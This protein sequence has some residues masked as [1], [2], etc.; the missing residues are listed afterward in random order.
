MATSEF[1]VSGMTCEHCEMSVREEVGDIDGV[2]DVQADASTG[3][4]TVTASRDIDDALVV[5]AVSEA[6]YEAV[7]AP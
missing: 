3:T 1:T 7:R 6:G 2:T 5:A 4:L